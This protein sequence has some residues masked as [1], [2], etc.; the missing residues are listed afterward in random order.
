MG[1]V[2]GDEDTGGTAP[3]LVVTSEVAGAGLGSHEGEVAAPV[4]TA[5]T[6]VPGVHP[7]RTVERGA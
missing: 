7:D 1:P 6:L 4:L 3:I 2:L 5:P